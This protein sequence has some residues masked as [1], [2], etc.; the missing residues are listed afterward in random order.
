M[1]ALPRVLAALAVVS[2]SSFVAL[3]GGAQEGTVVVPR[4]EAQAAA[5][6]VSLFGNEL[7]VSQAD[8]AASSAPAA[9]ANGTG[10]RL[11]TQGFGESTATADASTPTAGSETPVCSGDELPL[12]L[13]SDVPLPVEV[14]QACSSSLATAAE[15]AGSATAQA[16][17]FE[18]VVNLGDSPIDLG[19]IT[20]QIVDPILEL[21]GGTPVP[22]P[23]EELDQLEVLLGLALDGAV[24]V[25]SIASGTTDATSTASGTAASATSSAEGVTIQ[26]LGGIAATIS[27]GRSVATATYEGGELTA[28]HVVA[29]VTIT[30]GA[31]L[32]E[33]LGLPA[34]PIPVPPGQTIDLPLPDPL[35]SRITVAD[36]EDAIDDTTARANAA[37][38]RLDLATGL[39]GGGIVL[40]ASDAAAAVERPAEQAVPVTVPPADPPSV[41]PASTPPARQALPRTG[42]DGR[43]VSIGVLLAV[44]ASI[45][46]L[47]LRRTRSRTA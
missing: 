10:A 1:Q 43:W 42:G 18:I 30:P 5:V 19:E 34:T 7:V 4:A 23:V 15:G 29:P 35:T 21:L 16:Q 46:V 32:V 9:T 14:T 40:A 38:L 37:N 25:L 24:P 44:G 12:A 47:A 26:I 39:P 41:L 2:A 20:D 11:A 22:V 3:P 17:G 45:S 36:G 8:T 33:A 27:I 31:A 28:E 13:P 6:R